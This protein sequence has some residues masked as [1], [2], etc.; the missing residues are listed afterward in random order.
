MIRGKI[1]FVG[2]RFTKNNRLCSRSNLG[3]QIGKD[4]THR[5]SERTFNHCHFRVFLRRRSRT[6]EKHRRKAFDLGATD[7]LVKPYEEETLLTVIRRV[8]REAKETP[9]A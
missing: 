7:Y 8:A 5:Q 1:D 6:G 3:F 9:V 4:D 2:R